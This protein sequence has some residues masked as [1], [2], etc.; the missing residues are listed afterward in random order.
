MLTTVQVLL[1]HWQLDTLVLCLCE[2]CDISG[3]S[4]AAFDQHLHSVHNLPQ[5][6]ADPSIG[7]SHP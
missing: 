5:S 6:G 4:V 2:V 3:Q 1:L 7:G